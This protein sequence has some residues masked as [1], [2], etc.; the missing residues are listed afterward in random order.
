MD[1]IASGR[2]GGDRER[3]MEA[4]SGGEAYVP[5]IIDLKEKKGSEMLTWTP[6]NYGYQD[7]PK[8]LVSKCFLDT[9]YVIQ[10]M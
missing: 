6:L 9:F 10:N 8:L 2:R 5:G 3:G 4:T 7:L 1:T